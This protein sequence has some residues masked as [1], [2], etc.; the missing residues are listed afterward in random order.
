MLVIGGWLNLVALA[1][2][3]FGRVGLD[4]GARCL[5]Q[6]QELVLLVPSAS[7]AEFYPKSAR[8][9]MILIRFRGSLAAVARPLWPRP[10]GMVECAAMRT[11]VDWLL[12]DDQEGLFDALVAAGLAGLFCALAALL[13]WPLDMPALA[14]DLA[15]GYL[16]LW[17]A[18]VV[19]AALAA[20]VQRVLRMDAYRR[21]TAY[22]VLGLLIGGVLQ[23]GWS[24]FAASA[25]GEFAAGASIGSAVLLYLLGLLS[26]LVA[27][28]A[29]SVVFKGAIY[30]L[31]NLALAVVTFIGFSVWP[32]IG[33]A[34]V[35]WVSGL[36]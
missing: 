14:L 20:V 6:R 22:V 16:V 5:A 33:A 8:R 27:L 21:A 28:Q 2:A 26:C 4:L 13:L 24:A 30:R 32:D 3:I 7:L 12:H 10:A 11:L 34:L 36:F 31:V 9:A 29:V 25:V 35:G 23:A 15:K 17:A 1:D 19:A 18:I